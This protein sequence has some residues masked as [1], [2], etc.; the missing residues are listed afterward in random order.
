MIRR[1][2]WVSLLWLVACARSP[3][4]DPLSTTPPYEGPPRVRLDLWRP[5]AA[6]PRIYVEAELS[7]GSS[8]LFLVDTGAAVSVLVEGTAERLGLIATPTG[9]SIEGLSGRAELIS[10]TMPTLALGDA[11]LVDVDFAVGVPGVADRAGAL[12]VDGIL[13]NN[14]WSRFVVD[15]DYPRDRLV[16]HR[17]GS[18]RMPRSSTSL[19]FD[20]N[21]VLVPIAVTSAGEPPVENDLFIQVDTGASELLLVRDSGRPFAPIATEGIEPLYGIG[22]SE[23][24][25]PS[26]FLRTTRRVPL[27]SVRL[28]GREVPVSFDAM[29]IGFDP[30]E[31]LALANI[32]GLAGHE[33]LAGHRAVF[34]YAG[35]LF[36]LRRAGRAR[37]V[38]GHA[39]ALD[40]DVTQYGPDD[41][42]RA[43]FRAEL[44]VAMD[45]V[46]EAEELLSR[47]HDRVGPD[48]DPEQVAEARSLLAALRRAQGDLAGARAVLGVLEPGELVD[49][50]QIVAEVNGLLLDGDV[51]AALGLAERAVH[52][53]RDEQDARIALADALFAAGDRDEAEIALLDAARFAENPDAHLL[54]RARVALADGDRDGARAL[55]RRLVELYPPEGL[56][57]W[58]YVLLLEEGDVP[59]FRH[60]LD[61]AMARLHPTHRPFDYLTVVHHALGDQEQAIEAMTAGIARDC[62]PHVTQP[63]EDNCLA[64]YW[65]LAGVHKDESLTRIERAL[66][67]AG[68]RSDFL[69]TKAMVHLSRGE[70]DLAHAAALEAA[71]MSPDDIYMLWQAERIGSLV[72][73]GP[74]R[75]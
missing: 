42:T 7:D 25:P 21:H 39:R 66:T 22:A 62:D 18:V 47:W 64:W 57:L 53:R 52:E 6:A 71:R 41:L 16:L 45:R 1:R 29:W 75:P 74:E 70:R 32:K 31:P 69:D 10:T 67:A 68:P 63:D 43:P 5:G 11:H 50:G 58:F 2:G 40:R 54:R 12:R 8:G 3:L 23:T 24:L 26:R 30:T 59:T 44:L 20:G 73:S 35:G 48:A 46:D 17:P 51:S 33:L 34:D 56:F 19:F 55:I 36:A 28:G 27:R 49:Q 72:A 61:A 4:P 9:T 14:V 65:S 13:G 15:I 60:D 38:D 37:N